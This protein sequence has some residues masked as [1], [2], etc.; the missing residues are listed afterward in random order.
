MSHAVLV[1]DDD[2]LIRRLI[3]VTLQDVR[4][5]SVHEAEDGE[6]GLAAAA[7]LDPAVVLVDFEMPGISGVE[8]ARRLRATGSSA[9]VVMLTGSAHSDTETRAREAGVDRFLTKPFSPLE[10]L[11]LVDTLG[12]RSG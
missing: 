11:S 2:P 8:T 9:T 4:G 3:A 10:V 7:E 5:F 12:R 1:I 6:A